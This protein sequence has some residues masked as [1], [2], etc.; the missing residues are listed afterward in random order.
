MN[1]SNNVKIVNST[2]C[3]RNVNLHY[4]EKCVIYLESEGSDDMA[5]NKYTPEQDKELNGELQKLQ[6]RAKRLILSDYYDHVRLND[7]QYSAL[8][9]LTNAKSHYDV[10]WYLW[11]SGVIEKTL[12][13]IS[14]KIKEAKRNDRL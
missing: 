2:L 13:Y 9:M 8:T 5:N 1:Q 7:I 14:E 10:N 12:D 11:N 3:T 6:R 4:I